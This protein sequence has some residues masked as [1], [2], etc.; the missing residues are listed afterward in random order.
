MLA[1]FNEAYF[2]PM[3]RDKLFVVQYL[4]ISKKPIITRDDIVWIPVVRNKLFTKQEAIAYLSNLLELNPTL[5]LRIH[6]V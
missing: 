3:G 1:S 5:A 2:K 4:H 6:K